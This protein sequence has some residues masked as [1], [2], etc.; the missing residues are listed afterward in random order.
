MSQFRDKQNFHGAPKQGQ[1]RS[2]EQLTVYNVITVNNLICLMIYILKHRAQNFLV[3]KVHFPKSGNLLIIGD[4]PLLFKK[5]LV[6]FQ[7]P[8]ANRVKLMCWHEP[9][10]AHFWANS[11]SNVFAR[12][13]IRDML[14]R[15]SFILQPSRLIMLLKADLRHKG[16]TGPIGKLHA[17]A[18]KLYLRIWYS[19]RACNSQTLWTV[20]ILWIIRRRR[21]CCVTAQARWRTASESPCLI[22]PIAWRK[23]KINALYMW[24]ALMWLSVT[25]FGAVLN[26][27]M[28]LQVL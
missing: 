18:Q 25:H 2:L 28:N 22:H 21:S 7:Y 4:F 11:S 10:T 8:V 3:W 6:T 20:T 17:E 5:L 14:E 12:T 27:V 26:T 23:G 19:T 13:H 24:I 9:T 15:K 1:Y 16:M